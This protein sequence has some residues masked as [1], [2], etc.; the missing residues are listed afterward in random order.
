MRHKKMKAVW[1]LLLVAIAATSVGAE[2]VDQFE[3]FRRVARLRLEPLLTS[4]FG[5]DSIL[6]RID[7]LPAAGVL[8]FDTD[9]DGTIDALA[10][11]EGSVRVAALDEDR[12]LRPEDIRP[13][14]D[15]DCYLADIGADGILDRI[16]DYVDLDGD[17][18]ADR[19]DLY[20][21]THGPLGTSGLG[22]TSVMDLDDDGRL[23]SLSDYTYHANRD[24]WSSDF[25]GNTCFV[26]GELN[27]SL[28][29][30]V[31]SMEN[32]FCFYDN[33]GDGLSDEALRIE[34]TDLLVNSIRWSF[35]ADGDATAE[36]PRDYDFSLTATGRVR[37]PQALADSVV[38]RD[39]AALSFVSWAHARDFARWGLW[40]SVLL[41]WDE[42]DHNVAPFCETPDRE[43][44]E[45]VIADA[46]GG[47]AQI[48]GPSCGRVNKRYEID[49]DGS[50]RLG[51]YRSDVDDRLHLL[52]AEE[53]EFQIQIPA[54]PPIHRVVRYKDGNGNG[55]I[56]TWIYFTETSTGGERV[57]ELPDEAA[58]IVPTDGPSIRRVWWQL[59]PAARDR[60]RWDLEPLERSKPLSARGAIR[61]W[62]LSA[63]DRNDP[64]AVRA[65]RSIETDRFLY[66]LALWEAGGGFLARSTEDV[67]PSEIILLD[68]PPPT[69]GTTS[70]AASDPDPA[71][72][73]ASPHLRPDDLL[74]HGYLV[75]LPASA[76]P[77]HGQVGLLAITE[78]V[79]DAARISGQAEDWDG[80]SKPDILYFPPEPPPGSRARTY[81]KQES[82]SLEI[83]PPSPLPRPES[84]RV[85]PYL[86]SGIGFESFSIAY[87][88]RGGGLDPYIKKGT[89]ALIL[90]RDLGSPDR[91]LPWERVAAT[92]TEPGFGDLYIWDGNAEWRPIFSADVT[93]Q[94]R[95]ISQGPF[96]AVVEAVF[97]GGGVTAIRT[98]T[99]AGG[100]RA[101]LESLRVERQ[102]ADS[103]T[104]AFTVPS[105]RTGGGSLDGLHG[106]WS[107]PPSTRQIENVGYA[108][109]VLDDRPASTADGIVGGLRFT[110][111]KDEPVLLCWIVG[112]TAYGDS[113]A[114]AWRERASGFLRARRDR[115]VLCL[116][117]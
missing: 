73:T 16:V 49:R 101:I 109:A 103:T 15:N 22:V 97:T 76:Q 70:A 45:G 40:S 21:I 116:T 48:G 84:V 92:A 57:L 10:W 52:G 86:D 51:L 61:R 26:A 67:G 17:G 56:D 28:G 5:N 37:V 29:R 50:G 62:W 66:D 82:S 38:L 12:D 91:A 60:S 41:V 19:Q 72:R 24:Q 104:V 80:D 83:D 47:F 100:D 108:G 11:R 74:E 59:L 64:L 31:S 96:R 43:R 110:I 58:R 93:R 102:G 33:D 99:L 46:Y 90:R 81:T 39:G 2:D 53:G 34:G 8:R 32:P 18:V 77:S 113:T 25:D 115:D 20:E 71:R 63:R 114:V 27:D 7:S 14:R 117:R 79:R 54:D 85:D 13:D 4:V 23:F 88:I 105:G 9:G 35:D 65:Q 1:S 89:G 69:G 68:C 6:A 55:F 98:W 42:E 112:G 94:E 75:E 44:W 3:S 95:V 36:N 111:K 87:R 30:W 107:Y 106:V 78:M